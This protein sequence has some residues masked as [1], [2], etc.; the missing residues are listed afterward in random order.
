MRKV[1]LFLSAVAIIAVLTLVRRFYLD[2]S[3][4]GKAWALMGK[5]FCYATG[6]CEGRDS[7][8]RTNRQPY[9]WE[10]AASPPCDSNPRSSE[11]CV[12]E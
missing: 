4:T 3:D 9:G 10:S 8:M 11:S 5:W 1:N 12:G 2:Q 6:W 7:F